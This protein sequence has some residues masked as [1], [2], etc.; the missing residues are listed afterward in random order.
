VDDRVGFAADL[1]RH[2][3]AGKALLLEVHENSI[4]GVWDVRGAA[5]AIQATQASYCFDQLEA[6]LERLWNNNISK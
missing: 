2:P 6:T 5:C 3:Q 4:F 1:H